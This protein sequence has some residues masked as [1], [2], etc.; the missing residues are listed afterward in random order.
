MQLGHSV[1]PAS[2]IAR[3]WLIMRHLTLPPKPA[4]FTLPKHIPT[5]PRTTA[6]PIIMTW[7]LPGP[8]LPLAVAPYL[9]DFRAPDLEINLTSG[10]TQSTSAR[11]NRKV[12]CLWRTSVLV[13]PCCE[14]ALRRAKELSGPVQAGSRRINHLQGSPAAMATWHGAKQRSLTGHAIVNFW[15]LSLIFAPRWPTKP[16]RLTLQTGTAAF[17]TDFGPL[18]ESRRSLFS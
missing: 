18:S 17:D 16:A 15:S 2:R 3:F 6:V 14:D 1:R 12:Q 5:L 8:G 10:A 13:S 4:I 7:W 11:I 9:T